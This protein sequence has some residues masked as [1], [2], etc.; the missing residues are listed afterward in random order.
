[1][2]HWNS[3]VLV[4]RVG[5]SATLIAL[6]LGLWIA[7]LLHGPEKR[8]VAARW[9]IAAGL[10][11]PPAIL[12]GYFIFRFSGRAFHWPWAVAAGLVNGLPL[13]SWW[14]LTSIDRVDSRYRNAARSL[15]ASEWRVF[16]RI[17]RPLA[18]RPIL[19]GAAIVF[20]RV[21]AEFAAVLL[22]SRRLSS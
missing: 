13:L 1:M 4:M 17:S 21:S 6:A 7:R 9:L 18:W 12:C 5:L 19:A 22:I 14:L 11:L 2:P 3:L 8:T 16:L 20:A 15:G 10:A